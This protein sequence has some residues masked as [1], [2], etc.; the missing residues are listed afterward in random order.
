MTGTNFFT[1]S[2]F[3]PNVSI[4]LT[5]IDRLAMLGSFIGSVPTDVDVYAKGCFMIKADGGSG[6]YQ[7]VGTPATPNFQAIGGGA[8]NP[9]GATEMV[10]YNNFGVFGADGDFR[11]KVDGSGFAVGSTFLSGAQTIFAQGD[12]ILGIPIPGTF[13]GYSDNGFS[14]SFLGMLAGDFTLLSGDDNSMIIGYQ[15]FG[16]GGSANARY[17]FDTATTTAQADMGVQVGA[18]SASIQMTADGITYGM[19]FRFGGGVQ[20]NMAT[21]A[22]SVNDVLTCVA[23]G[24]TAWV[25][26]GTS[27]GI[28]LGDPITGGGANRLLYENGTNDIQESSNLAYNDVTGV[29]SVSFSGGTRLFIDPT[30]GRYDIG[31]ITGVAGKNLISIVDSSG[32]ISN[33]FSSQWQV[34]NSNTAYQYMLVAGGDVEIRNFGVGNI[35]KIGDAGLNGNKTLMQF[36][37]F[38]GQVFVQTNGD[39]GIQTVVGQRAIDVN[40]S[41]GTDFAVTIGDVNNIVTG[42]KIAVTASANLIQSTAVHHRTNYVEYLNNAAALLGGLAV[43][44]LYQTTVGGDAFVKR[45]I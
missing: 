13:S 39:F 4:A 1:A 43:G 6:L 27:S 19:Q 41:G 35:I 8:G 24:L 29:F 37:D 45:V 16:P 44:D 40:F 11:R 33:Q 3:N 26:G 21:N 22:P 10:Q 28:T 34:L 30:A 12:N 32:L 38:S 15:S 17:S 31:D 23:P 9:A 2:D 20:W 42:A 5:N 7:N 14:S 36:D 18:A 25:P